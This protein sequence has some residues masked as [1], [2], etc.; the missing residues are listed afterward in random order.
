MIITWP[1]FLSYHRTLNYN[2]PIYFSGIPKAFL[3]RSNF[4]HFSGCI[5]DIYLNNAL[6]DIA[7][8]YSSRELI[9]GC[10]PTDKF[11]C[12]DECDS[13]ISIW[14]GSTCSDNQNDAVSLDGSLLTLIPSNIIYI[15]NI[16][17]QFRTIEEHGVLALLGNDTAIEVIR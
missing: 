4:Y 16:S 6:V 1:T 13:C 7:S 12:T 5:K 8:A 2:T 3:P 14:N 10:S 11:K 15:S 17:I 9:P